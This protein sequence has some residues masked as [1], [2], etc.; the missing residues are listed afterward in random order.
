MRRIYLC[1][2]LL[3]VSAIFA[4]THATDV[5]RQFV[6]NASFENDATDGLTEV[7]NN[8]DGRRGWTLAQPAGW[9]VSGTGVTQ[10]LV[11]SDCYTDNNFGL[12]STIADGNAAYYLRMGWATGTT[13]VEQTL[14]SLPAGR[15]K[16]WDK[17][18]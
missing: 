14:K 10:L 15:Y 9:T 4:M 8:A 17:F 16:L 18:Q 2:M 13:T 5:T 11:T 12:V 1:M 6:V 7:T 3:W